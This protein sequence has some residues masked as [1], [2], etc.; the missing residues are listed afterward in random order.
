M[1]VPLIKNNTNQSY[2][3]ESIQPSTIVSAPIRPTVNVD[4]VNDNTYLLY[5]DSSSSSD[6]SEQTSIEILQSK[7]LY[8]ICIDSITSFF[9]LFMNPFF[10]VYAGFNLLFSY[11]GYNGVKNYDSTHLGTYVLY[12]VLRFIGMIIFE[13]SVL[14]NHD[15]I[16]GNNEN[17]EL[18]YIVFAICYT[19]FI[20]LYMYF[21]R[22]MCQLIQLFI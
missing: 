13:C 14:V 15:K 10:G 5:T 3:A 1:S 4:L 21:I 2:D 8:F 9:Y 22:K 17:S 16:F 7:V 12:N 18:S 19:C 6:T 20:L 11:I